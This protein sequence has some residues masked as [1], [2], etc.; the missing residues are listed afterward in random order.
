[1]TTDDDLVDEGGEAPC[2]L[3]LFEEPATD[4]EQDPPADAPSTR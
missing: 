3:H 1:M 4:D 2:F